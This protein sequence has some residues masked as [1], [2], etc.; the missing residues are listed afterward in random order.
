MF[1]NLSK[2]GVL[3][4]FALGAV[5]CSAASGGPESNEPTDDSENEAKLFCGGFAGIACP[6]G[7]VCVDD[8]SD[9]CDPKKG[10]ADCGGVCRHAPPVKC[11]YGDPKK[12]WVSKDPNQCMVIRF[13]CAEGQSY[14]ANEC[15]CGCEEQ[16]GGTPCGPTTCGA[17]QECCNP[18]CGICV[19][20]G[21]FCTQQVCY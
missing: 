5:A 1:S 9:G 21:G 20:T 7:Y 3:M 10:G 15:G 6:E 4:A 11:N 8:P 12:N 2:V 14:F 17:G 18:S 19:P 16:T 13:V